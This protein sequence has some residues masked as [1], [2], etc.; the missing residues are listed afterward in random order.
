MTRYTNWQDTLGNNVTGN[1]S[2]HRQ[3]MENKNIETSGQY[4]ATVS[5][6]YGEFTVASVFKALP[7]QYHVMNDI[8]LQIRTKPRLYNPQRYGQSPFKVV[9]NKK[10]GKYYELVPESTQLDHVIVST[11]GIFVIETKNHKGTVFGDINGQVWTQVLGSQHYTF[12]NPVRQNEGHLM[13]I[14][15]QLKLGRQFMTG[16]IVFTNPEARLGNVNCSC[17]YTIDMLFNGIMQYNK[18]L[19]TPKQ[20]EKVIHAIEKIDTNS[21]SNAKIHEL[22]VQDIQRR[23]NINCGKVKL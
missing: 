12:Y 15:K 18:I 6:M 16:M 21:Y 9:K 8:L 19:W 5:G 2:L 13:N 3:I 7:N 11:Y 1:G 4:Q 22:Y 10:N 20:V 23:K 17:C 14:S